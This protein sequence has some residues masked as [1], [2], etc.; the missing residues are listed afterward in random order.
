MFQTLK[1]N[2]K[3]IKKLLEL[4]ILTSV[5]IIPLTFCTS[6]KINLSDIPEI[7]FPEFPLDDSNSNITIELT[8]SHNVRIRW[9]YEKQEAL[10]PLSFW[11]ELLRYAVDVDSASKQY[12]VIRSAILSK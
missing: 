6:S 8:E 9:I 12:E 3:K 11:E 7:Y 10:M 5:L 4:V 1:K 2:Q